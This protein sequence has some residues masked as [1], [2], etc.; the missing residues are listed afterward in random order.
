MLE[1]IKNIYLRRIFIIIIFL[2]SPIS[3]IGFLVVSI[4]EF[5]Q[6]LFRIMKQFWN[7]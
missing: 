2:A 1:N 7:K 5:Y 3:L 4:K 6:E